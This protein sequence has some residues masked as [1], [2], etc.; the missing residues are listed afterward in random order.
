[1]AI[2]S[3]AFLCGKTID[4]L[5]LSLSLS[6]L[7]SII[8]IIII[9][10]E[11]LRLLNNALHFHSPFSTS[12]SGVV[13]APVS[14]SFSP[15]RIACP[16][17]T[18]LSLS[19]FSVPSPIG[20]TEQLSLVVESGGGREGAIVL[21]SSLALLLP[22]DPLRSV[23]SIVHWREQKREEKVREKDSVVSPLLLD[24][25]TSRC[26]CVRQTWPFSSYLHDGKER[27]NKRQKSTLCSAIPDLISFS[28]LLFSS[29]RVMP[30]SDAAAAFNVRRV[31]RSWTWPP[32]NYSRPSKRT[33]AAVREF[34][35]PSGI[36]ECDEYLPCPQ[37]I[38][39][40]VWYNGSGKKMSLPIAQVK[41][42]CFMVPLT[43][44]ALFPR[45]SNLSLS[46]S[47]RLVVSTRENLEIKFV[48][49]FFLSFPLFLRRRWRRLKWLFYGRCSLS[50]S[51]RN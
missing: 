37:S 26:C 51:C 16:T 21:H 22:L 3:A 44:A 28:P 5:S 11:I 27:G 38:S 12:L 23:W 39:S 13:A 1:M 8:I 34:Q 29:L 32:R 17:E 42:P 48:A 2:V 35:R 9:G 50:A 41:K 45:R 46:L 10:V 15:P 20:P 6:P 14:H 33:T 24:P 43:V 7:L 19:P 4:S 25:V 36:P 30:H 47:C 49:A 18:H 40:L 31:L